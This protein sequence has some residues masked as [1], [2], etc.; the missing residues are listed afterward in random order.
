MPVTNTNDGIVATRFLWFAGG[1]GLLLGGGGLG[2]LYGCSSYAEVAALARIVYHENGLERL[3]LALT[4]DRLNWLRGVLLAAAGLGLLVLWRMLAGSPLSS[5]WRELRFGV[6]RLRRWYSRLPRTSVLLAAGVLAG[7]LAVRTWYLFTYPLSTDEVGSYD[8]FVRQGPLAITGF[9][10]I[11][12]NHIGYNLLAWPL[13]HLGLSPRLVMRLPTL[14][15]G[16]FGSVVSVV[17]LARLIGLR[18]AVLVNGLVSGAPLWVYYATAGRG[19]F[20]QLCL[21][22]AGFFATIELLR[23]FSRYRHVAW[24]AF[25][26]SSILGFYLIPTYAYPLAGLGLG[27]AVGL[28]AQR[29]WQEFGQLVLAGGIITGIAALLYSPV[30]AISGWSLLTGNRYVMT[31]TPGQ[32]WPSYRPVLYELA[33]VLFGLPVRYSGP[34]W[35]A[36]AL[37]G[38]LA[39]CRWRAPGPRRTAAL[40]A[41]VQLALPLLL[42]AL[43]RVYAPAR[44]LLYLTFFGYLVAALLVGR[45]PRWRRVVGRV[46]WLLVVGAVAGIGGSRVYLDQGHIRA[47]QRETQQFQQ[48]Y[49]WLLSHR[50]NTSSPARVWM[51]APLHE[52]FFFHY[53]RQDQSSQLLLHTSR[54]KSPGTGYDFVVLFAT[55]KKTVGLPPTYRPVYHDALV[56]IYAPLLRP[57]VTQRQPAHSQT[58]VLTATP[59]EHAP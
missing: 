30:V 57:A 22:Q 17:L 53:L 54:E 52:L 21:L 6:G 49:H 24:L 13:V 20:L 14:L 32:F 26:S 19:Y 8:Y 4:P 18:A 48:A 34:A 40:L 55:A 45:L 33:E 3:T 59:V 29:R 44:V 28:A 42:M 36:G 41:W 27:A 43:Q 1:V 2:G 46:R 10:P 23:P 16:T 9:Y 31:R 58:Q 7:L 12:N 47:L 25:I 56:T 51:F 35:L 37:L 11:P 15:L 39:G 38:G 5:V 50:P